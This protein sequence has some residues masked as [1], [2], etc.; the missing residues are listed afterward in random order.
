MP[1]C[2]L[3]DRPEFFR[4]KRKEKRVAVA[5]LFPGENLGGRGAKEGDEFRQGGRQLVFDRDGA[6]VWGGGVGK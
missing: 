4:R 3:Q 6:N 2:L 5:W 1:T